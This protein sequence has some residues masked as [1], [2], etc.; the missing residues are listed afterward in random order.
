MVRRRPETFWS[1]SSDGALEEG[2]D[3]A[4]PL[5]FEDR[6][7]V[8]EVALQ[9]ADLVLFDELGPGALLGAAAGE[10]A[11]VD[12]RPFDAGRA[13]ERSVL[14]VQGLLAEDRLQELLLGRELGLALGGDLADQDVARLDLGAD[15]DDAVLVQVPQ[16]GL[17][18]VGDVLGDLLG[19]ELRVAGLD[20]LLDDVERGED[21]LLD[22]PLADDDRVLEVVAAPGHEGAEHVPAER[23]LPAVRAGAVGQDLAGLDVVAPADD[24]P[25]GEAGVLVRPEELGQEVEVRPD[26]VV[27]GVVLLVGP[28]EDA[29]GVD[30]LDRARPLGHDDVARA[31]GHEVLDAR[32]DPGGFGAEQRH[33]LALHVGAHQGAVGVVVLEERHQGGGEGDELLRRD[34]DVMDLALGQDLE[35]PALAD[36]DQ[37]VEEIALLVHPGVGLGDDPLLLLPGG[38]V[39]AVGFGQRLVAG[40]LALQGFDLLEVSRPSR[41][42]RPTRYSAS[43]GWRILT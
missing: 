33:G 10:D 40:L 41:R 11:D 9:P 28:D 19:P 20:R 14:D 8:V 38:Q 32:P 29:L 1:F 2:L 23:Q 39:E 3:L 34:V 4:P 12:D 42:C 31:L 25:L 17:G 36:A 35:V 22:Q 18:D 30:E 6:D 26:L 7:L 15:P 16:D 5:A 37:I 24:R 21:V 27:L 43:P 13:V